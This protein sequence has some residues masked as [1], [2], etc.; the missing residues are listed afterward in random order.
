LGLAVAL[1]ASTIASIWGGRPSDT[2]RDRAR[3]VAEIAQLD[4][5]YDSGN[6]SDSDYHARRAETIEHLMQIQRKDSTNQS[7]PGE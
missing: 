4:Q 2:P 7:I 5:A 1:F 6:L 3:L